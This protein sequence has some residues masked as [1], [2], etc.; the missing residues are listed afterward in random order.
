MN[1]HKSSK[2]DIIIVSLVLFLCS[3]NGS[4]SDASSIFNIKTT[5]K[6]LIGFDAEMIAEKKNSYLLDIDEE[7]AEDQED[8]G[9]LYEIG[10]I[11][12]QLQIKGDY[13]SINYSL[14]DISTY[15]S[16]PEYG[17]IDIVF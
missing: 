11:P 9:K 7:T 12:E 3:K 5:N 6:P 15:N 10:I 16:T 2:K 4:V 8:E 14:G 17:D 13:C 1:N